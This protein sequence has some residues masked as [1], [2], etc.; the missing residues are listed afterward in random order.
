MRFRE[1]RNSGFGRRDFLEV[2]GAVAGS[3]YLPKSAG[4]HV[5]PPRLAHEGPRRFVLR[6][7]RFGRMFPRLAPFAEPSPELEAALL[8]MGDAGDRRFP[9]E[10]AR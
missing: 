5:Q 1:P 10:A 4:A 9:R 3:A 8:E 7:D 2:M 6:E